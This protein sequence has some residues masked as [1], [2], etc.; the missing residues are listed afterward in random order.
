MDRSVWLLPEKETEDDHNPVAPTDSP[1]KSAV[2]KR[3]PVKQ[4]L[5]SSFCTFDDEEDNDIMDL[6]DA[7]KNGDAWSDPGDDIDAPHHDSS[8]GGTTPNQSDDIA[9]D[10]NDQHND[11]SDQNALEEDSADEGVDMDGQN[12]DSSDQ[13]DTSGDSD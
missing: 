8:H 4:G 3:H 9:D 1:V 13:E 7:I 6:D 10:L 5:D 12:D 11:D 2:P